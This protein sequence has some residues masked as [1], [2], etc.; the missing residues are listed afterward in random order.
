MFSDSDGLWV[1]GGDFI[2]LKASESS[3]RSGLA[4]GG[5]MVGKTGQKYSLAPSLSWAY[6]LVGQWIA[7]SPVFQ[8]VAEWSGCDSNCEA[9]R[10]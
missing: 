10:A 8:A 7:R 9:C 4:P 5:R 3:D 6:F 1:R 2:A